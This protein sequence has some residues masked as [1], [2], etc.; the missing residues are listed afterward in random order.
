VS[1]KYGVKRMRVVGANNNATFLRDVVL[2]GYSET[3]QKE[4]Q[5][6]GHAF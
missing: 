3:E 6:R 2:A 4:R 5:K 1:D